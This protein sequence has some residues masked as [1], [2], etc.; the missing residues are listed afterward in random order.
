M[1]L[2]HSYPYLLPKAYDIK[3]E[4][5]SPCSVTA[6]TKYKVSSQVSISR[7]RRLNYLIKPSFFKLIL[8]MITLLQVVRS[9]C[10][11][12]GGIRMIEERCG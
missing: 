3:N 1:P 12:S 10:E 6:S 7:L 4:S 2:N 11:W 9:L 5:G 8:N